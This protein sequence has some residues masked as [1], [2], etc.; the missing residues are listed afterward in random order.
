M[1]FTKKIICIFS[2]LFFGIIMV[3]LGPLVILTAPVNC[4][5]NSIIKVIGFFADIVDSCWVFGGYLTLT[6]EIT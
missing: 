6:D 4:V 5:S 1:F 2:V 3:A